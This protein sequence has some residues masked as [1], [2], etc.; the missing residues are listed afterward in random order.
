MI[1]H[2]L[3]FALLLGAAAAAAEDGAWYLRCP[4]ALS[5]HVTGD[6][7]QDQPVAD[8][9][10]ASGLV[11]ELRVSDGRV[12]ERVWCRNQAKPGAWFPARVTA[13]EASAETVR[14]ELAGTLPP[15][16]SP[17][18][19]PL[20]GG[21]LELQVEL[22]GD[23]EG[24]WRAAYS[25]RCRRTFD[26]ADADAIRRLNR[27]LEIGAELEH[28]TPELVRQHVKAWLADGEVAGAA[29]VT[30]HPLPARAAPAHPG[31][32]G[33]PR[34]LF[35][36]DEL[37]AIR[38][39]LA[40]PEGKR[41]LAGIE[42]L[43]A[44]AYEHGFGFRAPHADHS[45]QPL[46]AAA[47][48]FLYQL[49]R[50]P[51]R[52][53]RARR[54]TWDGMYASLPNKN[55]WRQ[56]HR[57]VGVALAY[58]LCA[59][60]WDPAFRQD[61]YN[62]LLEKAR[63]FTRREDLYDP[64]N[65]AGRFGYGGQTRSFPGRGGDGYKYLAA[66]GLAA[67]AI[68]GDEPPIYRPPAL[69]TAR[70]VA[71]DG[72]GPPPTGVPVVDFDGE[73]FD[74]WLVNGPLDPADPDPLAAL[75][76][77]ADARPVPGSVIEVAGVELDFR[78]YHPVGTMGRARGPHIYP[79]NCAKYWTSS[80]G[81]GYWPGRKAHQ[82]LGGGPVRICLYTVWHNRSERLVQAF[83]NHYWQSRGVRMWLAGEE[84]RDEKIV[85]VR[86]GYYP[87]MCDVPVTGGY[88]N[89]APHLQ[90][91]SAERHAEEMERY[92]ECRALFADEHPAR[93]LAE[94]AARE[95]RRQLREEVGADGWD[96]F[97]YSE[98]LLP[99]LHAYRRAT[100]LDLAADT[101]LERVTPL[102][103]AMRNF[104]GP[105]RGLHLAQ[106]MPFLD[107][108][109]R[110]TARWFL[111]TYRLQTRHPLAWLV[112]L[113]TLDP[114]VEPRPPTGRHPLAVH[115]PDPGV[116]L[117]TDSFDR[118]PYADRQTVSDNRPSLVT[119][120][121]GGARYGH[122]A[123]EL[124]LALAGVRPGRHRNWW[125]TSGGGDHLGARL[126]A[127]V[128][129]AEGYFPT[130]R[131]VERFRELGADGSGVVSYELTDLH[132]GR[133]ITAGNGRQHLRLTPT[134][135]RGTA[136]LRSLLVDFSGESGAETLVITADRFRGFT[137]LIPK[138]VQLR[139]PCVYSRHSVHDNP[140]VE[141]E[142]PGRLRLAY[143]RDRR[144]H[145]TCRIRVF[146]DRDLAMT[147][148]PRGR[149]RPRS[150]IRLT[151][152]GQGDARDRSA[153]AVLDRAWRVDG[154]EWDPAVLAELERLAHADLATEP[155]RP[156]QEQAG[157]VI[158][159][160]VIA[161][162][163]GEP[164]DVQADGPGTEATL[165]VGELTFDFDGVRLRRR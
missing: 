48:G 9:A 121:A 147:E 146:C 87:V 25:G 163:R 34:L 158:I 27:A 125:L 140:R 97:G 33:H 75:G 99:F 111:Q 162:A 68:A 107:P 12:G 14:V 59:E 127:S 66:A 137:S 123:E 40:T 82:E 52:L 113:C 144:R 19:G 80:T 96:A 149:P 31:D 65:L 161:L 152:D 30:A 26:P 84:L 118:V 71:P 58:D 155:K 3:L 13:T 153:E 29:E 117:F 2:R 7:F 83:P 55:Q 101:G 8:H 32:A 94:S 57:I 119:F 85:R 64:L 11:I 104:G 139:S 73:M 41:W 53:E 35:T 143:Y 157:D 86:P 67:L 17:P 141:L 108:A 56:S 18:G 103:V 23:G 10:H 42:G 89:Q 51:A 47:E 98:H 93:L 150:L 151:A 54:W 28:P 131:A 45:K 128:P 122:P 133:I 38:A 76:G 114:A 160:T 50:D 43:L 156:G 49:D 5:W 130:R 16:S 110:P 39:R 37:P 15:V 90:F 74:T 88:S 148:Q 60:G 78:Y 136:I 21:E 165:R 63:V 100:G 79:R 6:R 116:H 164:P 142:D 81:N 1:Q 120:R 72:D 91:Y 62:Y 77:F 4:G 132:P 69:D 145:S 124:G 20:V 44:D 46:W 105:A 134:P 126:E 135:L 106:S 95:I 129:R 154:G 102:V 36:R 92:H 109:D 61:V 22:A 70:P 138:T 24:G 112:G 159:Y 115:L